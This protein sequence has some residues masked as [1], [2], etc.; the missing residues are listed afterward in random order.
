MTLCIHTD[1]SDKHW[2]VASIQCE[3]TELDKPFLVQHHHPL[4]FISSAFT[5]REEHWSTYERKAFAV[6]QSFHKLD[7]LLACDPSTRVFTDHHNLL[8]VFNP[9]AMEPSLG[10]HKVLKLSL[11]H[12]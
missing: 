7:Y 1:A 8:F 9:I 11:I 2:A 10:R 12:I 5:E 6:V 4:A 3:Q